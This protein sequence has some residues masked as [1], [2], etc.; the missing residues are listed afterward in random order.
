M[1]SWVSE[2]SENVVVLMISVWVVAGSLFFIAATIVLFFCFLPFA[3]VSEV[4]R[5][6][7]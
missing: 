7:R 6:I 4:R 3:A 2:F 1:I 5:W